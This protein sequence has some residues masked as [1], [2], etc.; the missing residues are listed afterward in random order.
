MRD[1]DSDQSLVK[2]FQRGDRDAYELFVRRHQDRIYRLAFTLVRTPADAADATQEVF[3]RAMKGLKTFRFRA[4]PFTWL[5]RTTKNV[6]HELNRK[7]RFE[8]ALDVVEVAIDDKGMLASL[9]DSQCA[10]AIRAVIQDLPERQRDVV[11]LRYFEELSVNETA[12]ALGCRPGTVKALMHK[13]VA[14]L[15][16]N[17]WIQ[18]FEDGETVYD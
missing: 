2:R 6:C 5:Y 9:N 17:G 18:Q 3:V 12:T 8:P 16:T 1:S 10:A 13:A 7:H 4:H 11:L 15:R 14:K